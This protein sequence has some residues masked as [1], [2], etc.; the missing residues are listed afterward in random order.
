[1]IEVSNVWFSYDKK[2]YVLKEI[3]AEFH[4]GR[5]YAIMGDNGSGKTTLLKHLNGL[6]KPDKGK[7]L[8]DG[9]DTATTP[10]S[11]LSRKVALSFQNPEDMFFSNTVYDEV[12]FALKNFGY[13]ED[14]ID[15]LTRRALSIFNL[16][17]YLNYS[18]FNLSEGEKRRL[19]IACIY[20]WGPKYL[21]LDEPTAG[22]D[23]IQ[24]EMLTLA[25][26]P[27]SYTHLTLPTN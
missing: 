10:V 6:L 17:R 24:R 8:V 16:D 15:E 3:N 26:E 27:V 4:E 20:V 7:I 23:Q 5:Y 12:A 9:L 13:K 2:R 21:V 18:P 1:M 19:A 22:Q 25:I 14:K 11:V